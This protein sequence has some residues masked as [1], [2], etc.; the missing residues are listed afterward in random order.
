MALVI[1]STTVI[2]VRR[3]GKAVI[4]ADGQVSQ[5]ATIIKGNANKLR[6][7]GNG[8]VAAGFAGSTSD[9][10][11]LFERLEQKLESCNQQLT[12]SC[13]DLAKDWRL[14][15]YLRRLEAMMI[16]LDKKTTLLVSGTG[17]VLE[18][19]DGI[20]GI[21]SG[22]MYAAAAARALVEHSRLDAAQ[23]AKNALKIAASICVYTNDRA[24][25]IEV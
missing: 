20:I 1:R 5:G 17:D 11:T 2:A 23:I 14:D 21:G 4:A 12:R 8:R 10:L 18:P 22:G 7:L 19:E 13:V 3:N 16:V 15:K 24:V 9:A 25:M 6:H